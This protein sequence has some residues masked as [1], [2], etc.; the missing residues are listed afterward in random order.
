MSVADMRMMRW[1]SGKTKNDRI[2]NEFIQENL[3]VAPIGDKIKDSRVRWA[4]DAWCR[5]S[6]TPVRK[7]DLVQEE[8]LKRARG[9]PKRTWLEV[10]RKDIGTYGLT[11]SMTFN[12]AEW[13]TRI[14]VADPN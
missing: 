13:R 8:G 12:R 4:G 9:M 3:G 14:C 5:P 10:V 2:Q 11:E 1:M 7:C 6:T